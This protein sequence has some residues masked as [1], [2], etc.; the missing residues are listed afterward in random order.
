LRIIITGG[1]SG[2]G[3]ALVELFAARGNGDELLV[4]GRDRKKLAGIAGEF[5]GVH[6]AV[7]DVGAPDA[8]RQIVRA[9]VDAM[10]GVDA[11]V[12]NAGGILP[13]PLSDLSLA[14]FDQV[15][16]IN[17]RATFALAQAAYPWLR[18]SQGSLIAVGSLS[19][20][21]PT[22]SLGAYSVSKAALSM[23]I[24]QLAA[25]WGPDGIRCNLVSPGTTRTPLNANLYDDPAIRKVREGNIPLGRIGKP[26]DIAEVIYFLLQPEAGFVTGV[27]LPVDGGAR[28]MMMS[29]YLR[30]E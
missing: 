9:A 27:D 19:G 29:L 12:S 4:V 10:G 20:Q 14:D 13:G 25:E 3:R 7:A 24:Q 11:V 18:E 22:P 30:N 16:A 17:V 6:T 8:G 23:L 26:K 1:S 21:Y 5:P 2:I 15:M 28:T